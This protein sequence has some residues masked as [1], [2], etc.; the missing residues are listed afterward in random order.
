MLGW[1]STPVPTDKDR[2]GDGHIFKSFAGSTESR[3]NKWARIF[4]RVSF[5]RRRRESPDVGS[6]PNLLGRRT[7]S[8]EPLGPRC[9]PRN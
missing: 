9:S 7:R 3:P 2:R 1:S 6:V 5:A 8:H 4:P